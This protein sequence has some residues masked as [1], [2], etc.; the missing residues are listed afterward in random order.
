MPKDPRVAIGACGAAA[1]PAFVGTFAPWM[2]GGAGAG[3]LSTEYAW[4]PATLI[5]APAPV[6]GLPRYT[7]TGTINTLPVA[8]FTDT[9][10]RSIVS[11]NG[12]VNPSDNTPA[13]TT[14][15]GCVYPSAWDALGAPVPAGCGG[16]APA[17]RRY[18]APTITPA[19]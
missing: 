3:T 7:P 1:G 10:G 15:S 16:D 2:T 11:G 8:T 6:S 19:L 13:P 4:P 12:W 14:I 9:S 17:V 5:S 18:A